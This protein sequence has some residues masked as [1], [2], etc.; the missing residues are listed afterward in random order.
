MTER[1]AALRDR[2]DPWFARL[3]RAVASISLMAYE[4]PRPS[5][6]LDAAAWELAHFTGRTVIALRKAEAALILVEPAT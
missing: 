6:I 1:D 2:T 5:A 3:G 4:R